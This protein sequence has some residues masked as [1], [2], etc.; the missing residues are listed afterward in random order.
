VRCRAV[1]C[2]AVLYRVVRDLVQL[3][4]ELNDCS[5][6]ETSPDATVHQRISPFCSL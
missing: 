3:H 4:P 6:L 1:P 5:F 2:R